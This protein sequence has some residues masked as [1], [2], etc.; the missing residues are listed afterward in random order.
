MEHRLKIIL[1]G[2]SDPGK[3]NLISRYVKNEYNE[4]NHATIGI[5]YKIFGFDFLGK[6]IIIHIWDTAGHERFRLG[7]K[8]CIKGSDII[9]LIYS[10]DERTSFEE[11]KEYW[12]PTVKE[13]CRK[14][15]NG[16]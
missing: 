5:D 8:N 13:E 4:N 11:I 10:V 9:I 15:A 12:L 3:T 16:K 7:T 1:I 2:E 14:D 6:K